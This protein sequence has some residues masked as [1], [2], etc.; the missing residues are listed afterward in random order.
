MSAP[1][2]LVPLVVADHLERRG[3]S[4]TF[5]AV[6][7]ALDPSSSLHARE[8]IESPAPRRGASQKGG[9]SCAADRWRVPDVDHAADRHDERADSAQTIVEGVKARPSASAPGCE[10]RAPASEPNRGDLFEP[11]GRR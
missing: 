2:R 8:P 1:V 3:F 10:R 9:P 11:R 5:L 6:P 7:D 4:L